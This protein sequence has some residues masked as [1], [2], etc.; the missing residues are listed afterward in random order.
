MTHNELILLA[1]AHFSCLSVEPDP[2]GEGLRLI[3]EMGTDVTKELHSFI[4]DFL[5]RHAETPYP[6]SQ[7]KII[8]L[9]KRHICVV[10]DDNQLLEEYVGFLQ[11]AGFKASGYLDGLSALAAIENNVFDIVLTD[12]QMP[13]MD[14]FE[15]LS[16]IQARALKLPVILM[17]GS[18]AYASGAQHL[19]MGAADFFRKPFSLAKLEKRIAE[20]LSSDI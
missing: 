16:A 9:Q 11:N 15:L 4:Q 6:V 20:L 12:V 1:D 3:A 8:T 17:S 18:E 13:I 14:G 5:S 7:E 10:E 19:K 2:S